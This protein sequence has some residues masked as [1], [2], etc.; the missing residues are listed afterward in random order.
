ML[1]QEFLVVG[2]EEQER[3][4]FQDSCKR[5]ISVALDYHEK[6]RIIRSDDSGGSLGA[7]S[8]PSHQVNVG[9]ASKTVGQH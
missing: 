4:V 3:I 1:V 6:M 2:V 5:F 7:G 8:H 9:P